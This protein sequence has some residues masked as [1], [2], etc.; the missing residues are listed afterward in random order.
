MVRL[1]RLLCRPFVLAVSVL[2]ALALADA[3]V[4]LTAGV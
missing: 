1:W 2:V 4:Y 3:L